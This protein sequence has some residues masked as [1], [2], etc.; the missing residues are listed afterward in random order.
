MSAVEE[1]RG[2]REWGWYQPAVPLA[3]AAIAELEAERTE[4]DMRKHLDTE[5]IWELRHRAERAEAELAALKARRQ[6]CP[7]CSPP[8]PTPWPA[9]RD[10]I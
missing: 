1:Y 3:D 5:Q 7:M 6:N 4:T 10:V 9:D 2:R 8:V